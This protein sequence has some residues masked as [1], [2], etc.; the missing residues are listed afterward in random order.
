MCV[1]ADRFSSMSSDVTRPALTLGGRGFRVAKIGLT[2]S[3]FIVNRR[4]ST[5]PDIK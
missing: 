5:A 3:Y 2:G 4:Q 1:S